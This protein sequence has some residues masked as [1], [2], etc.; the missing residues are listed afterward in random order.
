MI[1]MTPFL[2]LDRLPPDCYFITGID[3]NIGKS[4]ATGY[5][6]YQL[7]ILNRS[8]ITQKPIQT[9]NQYFSDDILLHRNLMGCSFFPE[10]HQKLTMPVVLPYPA[11][12]HLASRLAQTPIDLDAIAHSAHILKSRYDFVLIEGAGGLFVPLVWQQQKI[13]TIDY[14]HRHRYSVILVTSGRLGSIN[15]T[16]M[17]L[18]CLRAYNI[19]VT[20]VIYNQIHDHHDPIICQD[21]QNF[22]QD[23]L[24]QHFKQCLWWVMPVLDK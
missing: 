14:L 22:L 10:D 18:S 19:N 16:L 24:N 13:L 11:S 21:T 9:G 2:Q 23:Y 8:V 12:P 7:S 4:Y 5:L 20:A 15:H 6:A 1:S 17:S 3:T